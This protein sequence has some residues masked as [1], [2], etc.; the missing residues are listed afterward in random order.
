MEKIKFI[1][2]V[3]RGTRFNQI[4][5]PREMQENFLPGY[6]VEVVLLEQENRIYYSKN[7]KKVN[8]FKEGI[9]KKIFLELKGYR[10]ISQIFVVGSFLTQKQDYNDIDILIITNGEI[11]KDI[12]KEI[13]NLLIEKFELKFHVISM[14]KEKFENVQKH[15]P[16]IRSML[17]YYITNK[18]FNLLNEEIKKD[19]ISFMLMMPSDLLKVELESRNYYDSIRRLITIERFLD[20]K[21]LDPNLINKEIIHLLGE[22]KFSQIKQNKEVNENIKKHLKDIIKEKLNSINKMIQ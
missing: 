12:E 16:I 20:K 14:T 10:E 5:I 6:L 22:E 19:H 17:Y 8:E 2:R 1:H 4:Y 18:Q 21:G 7:L 13:Y 3:S 15:D 11:K 9:V